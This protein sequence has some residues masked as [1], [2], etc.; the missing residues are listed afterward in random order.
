MSD[1][2]SSLWRWWQ[3]QV[4]PLKPK[5]TGKKY[6][7]LK[8]NMTQ[9]GF[10]TDF[11]DGY[12]RFYSEEEREKHRVIAISPGNKCANVQGKI[13]D[14]GK[15]SGQHD[16][17]NGR[18]N[19]I[20][21]MDDSGNFYVDLHDQ[22]TGYFHSGLMGGF[23]PIAAGELWIVEGYIVMMNEESGHYAPSGRLEIVVDELVHHQGFV[24][25]YCDWRPHAPT[26]PARVGKENVRQAIIKSRQAAAGLK[27]QN[28][29]S[30]SSSWK[31]W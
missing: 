25:L 3:G 20:W 14:W 6:S 18:S 12:S 22:Y 28:V 13:V 11:F 7:H 10:N 30:P 21:V 2:M 8:L 9:H 15:L 4:P 23:R 24:F 16:A 17:E 29:V 26:N 5:L 19:F 31:L 1:T 27:Q